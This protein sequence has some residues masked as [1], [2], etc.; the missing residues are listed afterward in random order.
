MPR[1]VAP[2][3][4]PPLC[5]LLLSGH[6]VELKKS[7]EELFEQNRNPNLLTQ[8]LCDP[9]GKLCELIG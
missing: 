7:C 6:V 4:L 5:T 2:L 8:N 9:T 1:V 3:A